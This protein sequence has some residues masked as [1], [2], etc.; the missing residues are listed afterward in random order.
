MNLKKKSFRLR[1]GISL[2]IFIGMLCRPVTCAAGGVVV[3]WGDNT[4]GQTNVPV[5]LTNAIAIAGGQNF[6]LAL[7]SDGSVIAWGDNASGQTNVP[8]ELSNVVAIA[9]GGYHA[10][11]LRA[12]GRVVAWGAGLTSS[13][14]FGQSL[15]PSD[16]TNVVAV[17]A[18]LYHSMALRADG[19]IVAWGDN[20]HS[21]T[22]VP[23]SLTN[24]M[25]IAAG[26]FYS[27]ALKADGTVSGWGDDSSNQ[28][29][30]TIFGPP[31]TL[32]NVTAIAAGGAGSL[33]LQA[34]GKMTAWG[35]Q[36]NVP[37]GLF[38]YP[39]AIVSINPGTSS[40]SIA[41]ATGQDG[42]VLVNGGTNGPMVVYGGTN[43]LAAIANGQINYTTNYLNLPASAYSMTNWGTA[44]QIPDYTT[45]GTTNTI[46]DFNRFI[47]VADLTPN[48]YNTNSHNNHFKN[49]VSF[50]RAAVSH[51]NPTTEAMEGIIVLDVTQFDNNLFNLT[52]RNIP[53]GINVKGTLLLNFTGPGWDPVNEKIIVTA[54]FN[55][56]AA[57]LSGLVATNPATYTSGYPPVYTDPTKNPINI[58]ITSRGYTNFAAGEKLPAWM[59]T[60]GV[61]DIHGNANICGMFY[62]PSYVEIE[63]KQDGQI[64]YFRGTLMMGHGAYL[65]NLKAST[66]I[67]SSDSDSTPVVAI[68]SRAGHNLALNSVG[69]VAAWGSQTDVPATLANVTAI[70]AGS[71]HS[72]ALVG[73]SPSTF[74]FHA[75]LSNLVSSAS[76][77]GF[78]LPTQNGRVYAMEYKNSLADN[79]W[80]ALPLASGNG[81]VL[82]LT[83]S[84]ATNS[85]RYYRV[86]Q[87]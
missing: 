63:T 25:A 1:C 34:N 35:N 5:D 13:P 56:N 70:A 8:M 2:L 39:A 41:K 52:S 48:G 47:A 40:N 71:A 45:Q 87:W 26:D 23:A 29:S 86:R 59:A 84:S 15:V 79:N 76:G 57:N 42:N 67:F 58:D 62:T 7:R 65:E 11:A 82:T 19:T 69:K 64:Q 22:N 85:Q 14:D 30:G 36:T 60:I 10:L 31:F 74:L 53:N 55:I 75:T 21:Q 27:L 3:A 44:S 54:A 83:D 51:T 50:M 20:S 33:A 18:G 77:F 68:T 46:F 9:A 6:S 61:V 80:T 49:I 32:N 4:F 73:S 66:S 81:G 37:P 28:I 43:G 17:A 72:L 12:D 78:S 38:G 16:L 24:V